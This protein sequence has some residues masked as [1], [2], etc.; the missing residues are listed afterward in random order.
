MIILI[1]TSNTVNTP[2]TGNTKDNRARNKDLNAIRKSS[3]KK[4]KDV[5]Q[6]RAVRFTGTNGV[7]LNPLRKGDYLF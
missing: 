4:R 7:C 6:Y 3:S 1:C 5:G 2:S